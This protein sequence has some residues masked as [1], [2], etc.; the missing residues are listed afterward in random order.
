MAKI[1][2]TR[3]IIEESLKPLID[4]GHEIIIGGEGTILD[5]NILKEKS[6]NS[7]AI[8]T[9][10]GDRIDQEIIDL[11][12]NLKV[13]ATASAGFDH[14]D[15]NYAKSKNIWVCNTPAAN[16]LCVAE[17]TMAF[18]LN[19]C[20]R[21]TESDQF[22][23]DGKY[24]GFD[25]RLM[26][27]DEISDN[28]LG[29][30]GL[31]AIGSLVAKMAVNGFGTKVK[32]YDICRKEDWEKDCKIEFEPNLD[33]LLKTCDIISLHVPL[34]ENTR[35]MIDESKLALMKPTAYLIN[36]C[37]G[38]VIDEVALV[39]ALKNKVIRGACLDVFENEPLLAPGLIELQNVIITPHTAAASLEAR[40]KMSEIAV[41]NVLQSLNGQ[42]PENLIHF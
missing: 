25:F 4:A 38:A 22:I 41:K 9:I 27:G 1:F 13:I 12:P 30:V 35:H 34:N 7:D 18:I 36:T 40:T 16:A 33:N 10:V 42:T 39:N 19:V 32:Y 37:R 26:I 8:I 28:V 20:H 21:I 29:I 23:R 15:G 24:K 2:I 5:R 31:G 14:I 6:T 3:N 17:H 11:S